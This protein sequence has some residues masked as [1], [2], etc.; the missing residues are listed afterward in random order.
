MVAQKWSFKLTPMRIFLLL[1]VGVGILTGL[2]RLFFG[3]GA[4]TNLNDQWP[5]GLW[6]GL[7][8]TAVAL[9][10]AGYSLCLLSHV[11]HIKKYEIYARRGLL[12]SF[13]LYIFVLIVLGLEV[14]RWDN[15]LSPVINWGHSSPLFEVCI[16][17]LVYMLVQSVE[18]FEVLTEKIFT[19]F[20]KPVKAIM[21]IVVI[22]GSLIPFGHQASLG[23]IYLLMPGKLHAL[24]W[25]TNIPWLFLISSF[26]AGPAVVAID[27]IWSSKRYNHPVDIK[28]LRSLVRVAGGL[29]VAY[30]IFKI[31]DLA[32]LGNLDLIFAGTYESNLFI[33]EMLVGILIPIV[34]CFSKWSASKAGLKAF[35]IFTVIGIALSRLNVVFTG[36]YRSLGSSYHPSIAE[37]LIG[38][39]VLAGVTVLY[40]FVVENFNIYKHTDEEENVDAKFVKGNLKASKA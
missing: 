8:L 30:F 7:D 2:F 10:G 1:L 15:A 24:W 20:N 19:S 37:W 13:L 40:I 35:G 31:V 9:A 26:F 5:W 21:P 12:I 38:L 28:S 3:L 6:I 4:S 29:M 25:S 27:T 39:G 14:G 18:I 34:I 11:L 32:R 36:M 33:V 17:I 16:A 22:I 23:A